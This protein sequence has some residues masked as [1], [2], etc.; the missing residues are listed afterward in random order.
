[1]ANSWNPNPNGIVRALWVTATNAF[2]GGDFTT[3]AVASRRGFASIGLTGTGTAQPL[4]L[5]LQSASTANLVRSILL[6]GT[7][8][9]VGGQFVGALGGPH[10][11]VVGLD[12]ISWQTNT[13][14]L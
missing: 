14:P 9:Y 2:V 5:A 10:Y 12:T 3:I 6:Q 13:V 11:L 1:M 4:D 7:N 8:L